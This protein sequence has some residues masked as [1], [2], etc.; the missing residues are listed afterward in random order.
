LTVPSLRLPDNTPMP[1]KHDGRTPIVRQRVASEK[2]AHKRRYSV[3]A[4]APEQMGVSGQYGPGIDGSLEFA[5]QPPSALRKL[6]AIFLIR[7]IECRSILH[8][9]TW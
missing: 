4:T 8:R 7:T 5:R 6:A 3:R 1:K 2:A 9:M